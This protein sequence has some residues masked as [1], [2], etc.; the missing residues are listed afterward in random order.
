MG[1]PSTCPFVSLVEHNEQ[2]VR[3]SKI[4]S[5]DPQSPRLVNPSTCPLCVRREGVGRSRIPS[6]DPQRPGLG[7]PSTCPFV[8]LVKHD[9]QGVGSS[10]IASKDPQSPGLGN[11]STCPLCVRREGVGRCVGLPQPPA[12]SYASDKEVLGRSMVSSKDP[13]SPGSGNPSTCPFV[14][15]RREGV[16]RCKTP[17][18]TCPF[19]SVRREGVGRCRIPSKDPQRPRLGKP[20]RVCLVL[21]MSMDTGCF[22]GWTS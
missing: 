5:K 10:R 18:T 20:S 1:N 6:K 2:G 3:K 12:H 16:G 15:V 21:W 22:V 8:S 13:Q 9:E 19:L 17:S 11:P 7:N 14:S 4:A